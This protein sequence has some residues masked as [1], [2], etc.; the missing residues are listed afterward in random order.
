LI[1]GD[2]IN[3]QNFYHDLTDHL[4]TRLS[5]KEYDDETE[6]T[7]ADRDTILIRGGRLYRHKT[8]RINFTTYDIRRSQD[9]LNPS[10]PHRDIMVH[11][12]DNPFNKGYHPFW[13]ARVIGIFHANVRDNRD[14]SDWQSVH[15]LWVRWFGRSE[16]INARVSQPVNQSQ[17]DWVGFITEADDT[18]SFGFLDPADVIRSCHLIPAFKDGQTDDL[19]GPSI[20][21]IDPNMDR[22]WKYYYINRFISTLFQSH[23]ILMLRLR[24]VDRDMLMMFMGGGVG[25][26]SH[27]RNSPLYPTEPKLGPSEEDDD[28]SIE[29]V[30]F[31]REPGSE[32]SEESSEDET[33]DEN[34]EIEDDSDINISDDGYGSA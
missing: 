1:D 33:D 23:Y 31:E 7:E 32:V 28:A 11:A 15:F 12:R 18:E 21:R 30:Q 17:L 3:D 24:F 13:Y 5:G 14:G 25:H 20:A 22:D 26:S 29:G 16:V 4:L 27:F 34:A 8:C 19:L 6:S 9:S 10:T 2:N